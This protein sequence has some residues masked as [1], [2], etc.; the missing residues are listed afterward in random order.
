MRDNLKDEMHGFGHNLS[1]LS[2]NGGRKTFDSWREESLDDKKEW[3]TRLL[4][5]HTTA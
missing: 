3:F 2:S 5:L 4:K 1:V